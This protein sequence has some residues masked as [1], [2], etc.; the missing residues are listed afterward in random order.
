MKKALTILTALLT[1]A[2]SAAQIMW[3]GINENA[4][5]HID[6][7][8]LSLN[9]WLLTLQCAPEDVG[10]RIRIGDAAMPA[11]FDDPPGQQPPHVVFDEEVSEFG[12]LVTDMYTGDFVSYADWQPIRLDNTDKSAVVY[13]DIGYW[14]E[15]LDWEFVTVATATD[16]LG[17]LWNKHT[18]ETGTL[19]PPTETPW[20]PVDYYAIPEPRP[21]ILAIL[22]TLFL[23]KRRKS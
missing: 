16:T 4:L 8:V 15:S 19:L 13:Y 22:G 5:V 2:A 9:D 7:Q 1:F 21:A 18:Y 14:D 3:V 11:G 10:A 17:N 6:N 20:K 12:I 23:L